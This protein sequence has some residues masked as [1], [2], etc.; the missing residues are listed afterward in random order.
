MI[1]EKKIKPYV[2]HIMAIPGICGDIIDLPK[3]C[4]AIIVCTERW[5]ENVRLFDEGNRLLLTFL[6]YEDPALLGGFDESDA[7]KILDFLDGLSEEVTDLYVC[8]SKGGSR[9]AAVAAAL[10]KMSGRSELLVWENP[11]YVPNTLV[12]ARLLRFAGYEIS[13]EEVERLKALN[14]ASFEMSKKGVIKHERWEILF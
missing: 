4:N 14:E 10:L 7:R 2:I 9:S 12:Y 5:N 6:D 3:E 8:C 1:M 11:F 13:D